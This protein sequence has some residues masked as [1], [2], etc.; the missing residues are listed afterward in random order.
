[1]VSAPLPTAAPPRFYVQEAEGR[2]GDTGTSIITSDE[3]SHRELDQAGSL[4]GDF[5]S[6]TIPKLLT[7]LHLIWQML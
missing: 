5:S 6:R 7:T 2:E 4:Q 1:M 3:N